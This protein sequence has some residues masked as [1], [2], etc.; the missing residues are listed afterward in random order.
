MAENSAAGPPD[1]NSGPH[2][3]SRDQRRRNQEDVEISRLDALKRFYSLL[4]KLERRCGG[5][6]PISCCSGRMPWSE[7]GVYFLL[8][9]G[10]A[11]TDSGTGSRVVRVGTH[12]LASKQSSKLWDRLYQH[13]GSQSGSGNHRGSIFR[14][15]VG[16]ALINR[17]ALDYPHWG[18]RNNRG[19]TSRQI[20]EQEQPLE[21]A[22]SNIIGAMD[23]LWLAVEDPPGPG[24]RRG[25][26]ERNAIALLS[27]HDREA[28]DP[29]SSGWLG[30]AC[31]KDTVT[32]SGLWNQQHAAEWCDPAFFPE[33]ERLVEEHG[34]V[35]PPQ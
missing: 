23:V 30:L 7:G 34:H 21:K 15:L 5:R 26:I 28:L 29:P 17:D 1:R 24:N 22:V 14:D 3:R 32:R 9:P 20:R 33:F 13:R 11:R 10:E 19:S 4:L 27:N 31:P 8:E 25:W 18:I 16:K 35:D 6:R 2:L 12:A